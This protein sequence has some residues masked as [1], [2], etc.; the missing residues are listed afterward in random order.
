VDAE[1]L[2]AIIGEQLTTKEASN[3]KKKIG[4]KGKKRKGGIH[5]RKGTSLT[6]PEGEKSAG[7]HVRKSS[8]ALLRRA[9][10]QRNLRE[11]GSLHSADLLELI[12]MEDFV[13]LLG[14]SPEP[15]ERK[16]LHQAL[17]DVRK[18]LGA[19]DERNSLGANDERKSLGANDVRKLLGANDVVS[20]VDI[21]SENKKVEEAS[22]E[23]VVQPVAT[24][25]N[26]RSRSTSRED[27]ELLKQKLKKKFEQP[28]KPEENGTLRQARTRP[29]RRNR[30]T[31]LCQPARELGPSIYELDV[32]MLDAKKNIRINQRQWKIALEKLARASSQ[33]DKQG[34]RTTAKLEWDVALGVEGLE[35]DEE[36]E[37]ED[38][39]DEDGERESEEEESEEESEEE[40]T[41]EDGI[42]GSGEYDGGSA[43]VDGGEGEEEGACGDFKLDLTGN[44]QMC[45][46]G[47][48]RNEHGR[49]F[50][51]RIGKDADGLEISM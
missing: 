24:T 40:E 6:V 9:N 47:F 37:E 31:T 51:L 1:D 20:G 7:K 2:L 50:V 46:C 32:A 14:E 42:D 38:G 4:K 44:Y 34:A 30:G 45:K 35:G 49:K 21:K 15:S 19:N 43:A 16:S 13:E 29:D 48:S 27:V 12:D 25:P 10:Q 18:S 3:R 23:T 28:P 22:G 17:V 11:Y 36:D 26:S 41:C 39:E 33:Q 8:L 5:K